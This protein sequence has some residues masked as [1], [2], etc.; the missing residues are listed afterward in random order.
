M[1]ENPEQ[2]SSEVEQAAESGASRVNGVMNGLSQQIADAAMERSVRIVRKYVENDGEIT[3]KGDERPAAT[4]TGDAQRTSVDRQCVLD[5]AVHSCALATQT[6]AEKEQAGIE[7]SE[8]EKAASK[9][10]EEFVELKERKA[11]Q[12][13][14]KPDTGQNK[15]SE[16][17]L[18]KDNNNDKGNK[19]DE[20]NKDNKDDEDNEES[21]EET[22]G[23]QISENLSNALDDCSEIVKSQAAHK[24]AGGLQEMVNSI[25]SPSG[26]IRERFRSRPGEERDQLNLCSGLK[27]GLQR[28]VNKLC[29]KLVEKQDKTGPFASFSELFSAKEAENYEQLF[30]KLKQKDR[31]TIQAEFSKVV[32]Q[33]MENVNQYLDVNRDNPKAL[34]LAQSEDGPFKKAAAKLNE[35]AEKFKVGSKE[36][37]K[38]PSER[39]KERLDE[40]QQKADAKRSA[41]NKPQKDAG[42][43]DPAHPHAHENNP[44]NTGGGNS[45][46][47]QAPKPKPKV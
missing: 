8:L 47:T 5:G 6:K 31:D 36:G 30:A 44:S 42:S 22:V 3:F 4:I 18:K 41:E 19:D 16:E 10:M 7:P 14:P 39:L 29:E 32:D 38:P 9:Q 35:M 26:A 2:A 12:L 46:Q 20:D 11:N 21:K 13:K 28:S 25:P 43:H 1:A 27:E 15:Q 24:H 33:F 23:E 34:E 40:H 17:G 37:E 45:G